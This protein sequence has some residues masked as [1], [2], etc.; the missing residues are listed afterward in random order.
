MFIRHARRYMRLSQWGVR[1]FASR[2]YVGE[3]DGVLRFELIFPTRTTLSQ[4]ELLGRPVLVVNTASQCLSAPTQLRGLQTLYERFHPQGLQIVAVPSNEF[5][6]KEPLDD[7]AELL[8][9]YTTA[10]SPAGTPVTF[11]IARKAQVLGANAHGFFARI[12][13]KYGRSVAPVWNFD[14]FL[15]DSYGDLTAVFPHDTEP[16]EPEVIEAIEEALADMPTPSSED[17]SDDEYDSDDDEYDSDDE[18]DEDD[19]EEA[20]E[21][22]RPR[23]R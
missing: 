1:S 8:A 9:A 3:M 4:K 18:E 13:T 12:A 14:K 23:R 16:L 21:Q 7:D 11:P 19:E 22:D 6:R 20:E 5:D 17:D 10:S 15:V 2:R